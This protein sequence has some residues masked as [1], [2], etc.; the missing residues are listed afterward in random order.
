[1]AAAKDWINTEADFFITEGPAIFG[2]LRDQ[3]VP[4]AQRALTLQPWLQG[5]HAWSDAFETHRSRRRHSF[6]SVG[7]HT[8]SI[9]AAADGRWSLPATF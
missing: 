8:L 1:V 5:F 9:F 7:S 6:P 4:R 3:S 2:T